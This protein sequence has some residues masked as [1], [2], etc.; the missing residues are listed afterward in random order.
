MEQNIEQQV[1]RGLGNTPP[2]QSKKDYPFP[3]EVISLPSKGLVYPESSPLS[4]GE[5]T[6]KLMTAKE[7]DILT[8]TNL[9]R[10][11]IVLDKLLESIIVDSS[12]NINDLIIGDKNAILI[13][14]RILAFG[15]E[16]GVTINDPN[17]NEPVEVKVDMSQLKIKEIDESKLNRNNEYEFILPKTKTP[18][19]FKIMTHGD[20]IAVNKDIEASEKITKQGNDIQ[21]RYRRLITEINGNR[22][23][24]YISNYV[25]NQLL[26]ADSKA[27]RKHISEMSPDVDLN[28]DYTSPFTGETEALK[29]PLGINFFYPAD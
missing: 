13:S 4:S 3:T 19:K 17:E 28:F 11:G 9:I 10:K 25:A 26:A 20:E 8:S 12:I 21:A 29:V 18:I 14:S 5:I 7:E 6:V 24:G 1:T 27:L 2:Q 15:P 22:E 16:Y 23:I